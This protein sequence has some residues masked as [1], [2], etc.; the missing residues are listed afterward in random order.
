MAMVGATLLAH[1][2]AKACAGFDPAGCPFAD[3]NMRR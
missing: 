2:S 3:K 1:V